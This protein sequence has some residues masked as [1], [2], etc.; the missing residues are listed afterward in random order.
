MSPGAPR[1]PLLAQVERTRDVRR[2]LYG[3]L[4][5]LG[6]VIRMFTFLNGLALLGSA[7]YSLYYFDMANIMNTNLTYEFRARLTVESFLMAFSGLFLIGLERATTANE[8]A[9]RSSLGFAFSAGGRF[10]LLIFL[11]LISLPAV[12][13]A[14]DDLEMYINGGAVAALLVSALLQSWMLSCTPEYRSHVVAERARRA[15]HRTRPTLAGSR[16]PRAPTVQLRRVRV[17]MMFY[18]SRHSEGAC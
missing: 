3:K 17:P 6:I 13:T 10:W 8:A 4:C 2:N 18:R 15:A 12:H 9:T 5:R 16:R 11:V 14:R 7:G 1:T